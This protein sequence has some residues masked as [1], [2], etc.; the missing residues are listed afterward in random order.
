VIAPLVRF[1]LRFRGVVVA[2]ACVAIAHGLGVAGRAKLDVFPEFAPPQVILQTEAPG[3]STDQ[4]EQLVTRPVENAV[5]GVGNLV[6]I[7]SQSIQGFSLITA[8]FTDDTDVM[9]ARQLVAERLTQVAGQL[10]AGA[11]A[12]VMAPLMSSTSLVLVMG[13]R[14]EKRTPME[15]RT[16]ADWTLRPR[17]LGVP[18]VAN[19]VEFGGEVREIQVQL[20]P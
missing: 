4:V 12:P 17:L 13:L 18:G 20:R 6:S 3:L 15:L 5:N 9:R 14:S 19:V 11:R 10:P 2:L 16:F 8:I 1:S 7:R